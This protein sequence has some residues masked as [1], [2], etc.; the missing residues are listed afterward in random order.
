MI[1][2]LQKT[3]LESTQKLPWIVKFGKEIGIKEIVDIELCKNENCSYTLFAINNH[4]GYSPRSGHYY[5]MIFLKDLNSWFQFN[6]ESVDPINFPSPNLNNY[7]L[8][9]K[10]KNL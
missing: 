9:Y 3:N 6:D 10:Q 2:S 5:S 8:V 4:I 7:I 1:L